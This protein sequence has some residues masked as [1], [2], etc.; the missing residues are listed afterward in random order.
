[1]RVHLCELLRLYSVSST[2]EPT[3]GCGVPV[4]VVLKTVS[5]PQARLFSWPQLQWADKKVLGLP[6]TSFCKFYYLI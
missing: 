4:D 6:T 1:M 5:S 3:I 2:D